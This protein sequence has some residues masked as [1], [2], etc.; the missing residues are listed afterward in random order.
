MEITDYYSHKDGKTFIKKNH[1]K[2][3]QDIYNSVQNINLK[4][5]LSKISYE[6]SKEDLIFFL[7]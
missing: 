3:L 6:V 5:S 2:E 1:P 4:E 7:P